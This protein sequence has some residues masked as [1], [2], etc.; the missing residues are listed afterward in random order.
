MIPETLV[1]LALFAAAVGPG[2]LY[3]RIAERR[4]PRQERTQLFEAA[5]LLVIGAST[6]AV[7]VLA[8]LALAELVGFIDTVELTKEPGAYLVTE[9]ARILPAVVLT[10]AGSYGGAWGVAKVVHRR[11]TAEIRP[12][13]SGWFGAFERDRPKDSGILGTVELRDGRLIMGVVRSATTEQTTDR[14]ITLSAP[15]DAPLQVRSADGQTVTAIADDFIVLDGQDV[16]Y[17]S[18]RYRPVHS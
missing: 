10:L 16:L 18:G 9:P 17:V 6:T 13:D 14:S 1:G 5:E 11:S 15:L 7:T 12:N 2:Y 3:V 8:V 4:E